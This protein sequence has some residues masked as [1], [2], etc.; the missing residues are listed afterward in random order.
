MAFAS[1]LMTKD[2]E[3]TRPPTASRR[4]PAAVGNVK[5]ILKAELKRREMTY[6]DLVE[7]L[8]AVGIF[9]SEANLRNKISRGAFTAA[10]F[11]QCLI[12]I[13]CEHVR[14]APPETKVP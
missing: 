2:A 4:P 9:E 3:T 7:R 6:A 10:F 14:I 12:A 1:H 11:V 13:G 8:A 5:G